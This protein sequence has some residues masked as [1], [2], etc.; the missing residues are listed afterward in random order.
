MRVYVDRFEARFGPLPAGVRVQWLDNDGKALAANL[1]AC[2]RYP[3]LSV[4]LARVSLP[5]LI[6]CGTEDDSFTLAKLASQTMPNATFVALEGL[7]LPQAFRQTKHILPHIG[8]FLA[9][10]AYPL[11]RSQ[12]FNAEDIAA[13]EPP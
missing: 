3:D 11:D 13:S 4:P 12:V 8:S 5:T 2:K 10:N 6:Y 9:K 7:N 1:L